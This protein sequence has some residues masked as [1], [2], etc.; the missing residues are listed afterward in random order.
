MTLEQ[1][2]NTYKEFISALKNNEPWQ[3][4]GYF[5]HDVLSFYNI[6]IPQAIY[7]C[8]IVRSDGTIRGHITSIKQFNSVFNAINKLKD[9]AV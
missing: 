3:N 8:E 5:I 1:I 9:I 6:K 7:K 2:E 4:D